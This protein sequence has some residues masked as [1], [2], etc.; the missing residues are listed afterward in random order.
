MLDFQ[1][2]ITRKFVDWR[3]DTRRNVSD[4]AQYLNVSQPTVSA[5]INGTRGKPTSKKV[6]SSL[7]DHFG[8]EVYAVLGLPLPDQDPR[9]ALLAAGFPTE[10]VDRFLA[11]RLDFTAE[12]ASKG[13]ETDSPE[14]KQIVKDAFARHGIQLIDT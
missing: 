1:D 3:K 8:A 13:I 14:A 5:W 4:F 7:V 2:W 9:E 10:Y 11:A 12:L 6:V